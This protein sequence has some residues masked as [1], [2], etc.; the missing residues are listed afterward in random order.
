MDANAL[1]VHDVVVQQQ[2]RFGPGGSV[3]T[4]TLV[5]FFVGAHGPFRLEY[6]PT[7]ATAEKINGDID[8]QVVELRRILEGRS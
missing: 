8:H 3:Q 1:S 2:P 4:V 7:Q 6:Q 5:S